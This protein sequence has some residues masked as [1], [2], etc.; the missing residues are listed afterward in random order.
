[1]PQQNAEDTLRFVK[2][3]EKENDGKTCYIIKNENEIWIRS[4]PMKPKEFI[5]ILMQEGQ[6]AKLYYYENITF[7]E[8]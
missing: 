2:S 6:S 4:Q 7:D 5:F 3:L 8:D 1:M